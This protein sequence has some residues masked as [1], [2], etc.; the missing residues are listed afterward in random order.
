MLSVYHPPEYIEEY[1][2]PEQNLSPSQEKLEQS[3]P[4]NPE[5]HSQRFGSTHVPFGEHS[6]SWGQVL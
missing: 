3:R 6:F 1:F 5:S 2:S 4:E